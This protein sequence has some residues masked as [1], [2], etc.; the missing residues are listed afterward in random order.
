MNY[1]R[2]VII[3]III[4]TCT[5]FGLYLKTNNNVELPKLKKYEMNEWIPMDNDT[6]NDGELMTGYEVMIEDFELLNFSQYQKKYN[7]ILTEQEKEDIYVPEKV[8]DVKLKVRNTNKVESEEVGMNFWFLV[9]QGKE[10]YLDT[11]DG[12]YYKTNI[13]SQNT[14]QF[15]LRSGTE[16]E[17]NIPFN[18]RKEWFPNRKWENIEEYPFPLVLT[19]YPT[20]KIV[21]LK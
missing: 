20:K 13:Q 15:A 18:L 14:M 4:C 8:Y 9:L 12:L 11:N 3:M 7:L 21:E 19:K 2:L 5:W 6:L 1:K 16:M 10:L 17:F